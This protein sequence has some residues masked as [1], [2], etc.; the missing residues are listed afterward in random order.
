MERKT[1]T[2]A[3]IEKKAQAKER[4]KPEYN[5]MRKLKSK[6]TAHLD[7]SMKTFMA[8]V[9]SSVFVQRVRKREKAYQWNECN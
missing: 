9:W 1:N 8:I 4:K 3:F 5:S 6:Q 2:T 7:N